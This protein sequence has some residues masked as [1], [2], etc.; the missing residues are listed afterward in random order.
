MI[1]AKKENEK[2][3]SVAL[4]K[5]IARCNNIQMA[6]KISLNSAYIVTGKQIGRAHV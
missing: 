1:E 5:E 6:K 4:Q 3:P 2:T